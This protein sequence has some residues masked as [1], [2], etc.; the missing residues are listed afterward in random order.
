M[1]LLPCPSCARHVR[2]SESACP[3]CA[4][5]LTS[6]AKRVVPAAG[7]RL[8]RLAAFT[9]AATVTVTG[10]VAG[11]EEETGQSEDELGAVQPMYGMP[12]EQPIDAGTRPDSGNVKPDAATD[13]GAAED[14]G[15]APCDDG[16]AMMPMYGMPASPEAKA[17]AKGKGEPAFEPCP[18]EEDGGTM[19]PMYGMPASEE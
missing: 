15:P 14:A 18:I 2:S 9:F 6:H 7:R 3:F 10:C 16:G 19:M 11:S 17:D 1:S 4:A 12:P 5:S 13:G 8:E